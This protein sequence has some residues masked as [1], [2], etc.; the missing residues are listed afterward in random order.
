MRFRDSHLSDDPGPLPKC[1]RTPVSDIP[2]FTK[3][4]L[5]PDFASDK[6]RNRKV[7]RAREGS[8]GVESVS[9]FT[10]PLL[11]SSAWVIR[12]I[13]MHIRYRVGADQ[14]TFESG[15]TPL[16][17]YLMNAVG[18]LVGLLVYAG[19]PAVIHTGICGHTL[20]ASNT[21]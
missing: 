1:W 2:D 10:L 13:N 17:S 12:T 8:V 3:K 16:P 20:P 9:V 18:Q 19:V 21:L 7:P 5:V 11:L 6:H 15:A 14:G 4:S